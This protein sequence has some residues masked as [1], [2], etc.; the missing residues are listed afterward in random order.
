MIHSKNI[1]RMLFV[2]ALQFSSFYFV[3]GQ[4]S[5]VI[6]YGVEGKD[7]SVVYWQADASKANR[8][9]ADLKEGR[10]MTWTGQ[11]QLKLWRF[12]VAFDLSGLP[13]K[14]NIESAE[15]YLYGVL[16]PIYSNS[17]HLYSGSF[18][19]NEV[20]LRRITDNTWKE[21]TVTWNNQPSTSGMNGTYLQMSS[22]ATQDYIIDVVALLQD[23]LIEGQTE[24]GF[25]LRMRNEQI[26]YRSMGFQS[27]DNLDYPE[28][29]P[30]LIITY[31]STVG[32]E[33]DAEWTLKVSPNPSQSGKFRLELK[34]GSYDFLNR[35]NVEVEVF[36][37]LGNQVEYSSSSKDIVDLS[38]VEKGIYFVRVK[39]NKF[40]KTNKIVYR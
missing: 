24:L 35:S 21:S 31:T 27:S 26:W 1:F 36:D 17:Q 13:A 7:A 22:S 16:D 18:E 30:K 5:L 2:I 4:D 40:S 38:K 34:G 39:T 37:V 20:S 15:L 23:A 32:L 6:Q 25:V 19:S 28:R 3:N 9:F 12:L 29:S 33:E 14:C 11:G 8:N 10:I